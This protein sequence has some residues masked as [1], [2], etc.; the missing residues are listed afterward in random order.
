VVSQDNLFA[1]GPLRGLPGLAVEVYS[2]AL[3]SGDSPNLRTFMKDDF[4][5]RL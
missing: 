1:G 3:V 4:A 5:G 2:A